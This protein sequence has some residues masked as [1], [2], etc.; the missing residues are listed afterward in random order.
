MIKSR[1]DFSNGSRVTDHADSSHNL[2]QI[3]SGDNSRGLVV[4]SDLETSRAPVNELDGSLGLNGGNGS[5]DILGDDITSI[6]HRAGH[7]FTMSGVTLSHHG[8]GFKGT[9][10]DFSN[11]EL[12]VISLFSRD[13]RGIRRQHEMDSGIRYQIGLEFSDINV[14]GTIESKGSGQRRDDLSN[15]SVQVGISGSFDIQLSTA[16]VINSF[17]IKHN[18]NISMFQQRV[19]GK[20]TVIRFNNGSR[21]LRRRVHG[22]TQLGLFAVINGKSFQQERTETG[23][24]SSTNGVED[25]ESLKTGTV[26][27]Q[28]S[29]SVKA[30]INDFF[31]NGVVTSGEVVSSIFFTGDQ[32]FGVEQL[33]ISTSSNFINNGGF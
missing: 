29:D 10:G 16:Y 20:D 26:V 2:S 31:T 8:G 30:E 7:V 5:V 1:E 17:V 27:S 9:V 19:S 28:L 21:N 12:F 6:K 18:S 15:E 14:K 23:S 22:E 4:D 11:R 3:T 32:L 24:S 33:S 13:D 25:H